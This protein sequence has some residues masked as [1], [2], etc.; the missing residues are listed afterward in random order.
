VYAVP[1]I[2]N[3]K[4]NTV[5][6][7]SSRAY[8]FVSKE[9][10][11]DTNDGLSRDAPVNTLARAIELAKTCRN[12]LIMDGTYNE[13]DLLV[14]YDLN[15]KG[16]GN[17]T[18]TGYSLDSI[19]EIRADYF[20][21]KNI[22]VEWVVANSFIKQDSGKS[23]EISK[24]IFK[25]NYVNT[26]FDVIS[27]LNVSSSIIINNS[28]I[29]SPN[30]EDADLDFNWWGNTK[31][32]YDV[33]PNPMVNNWLFLNI[34]ADDNN[35]QLNEK[36]IVNIEYNL[37]TKE[38]I[39]S[40]EAI[41]LPKIDMI[42][43]SLNG[44]V[45]K[46]IASP[47]DKIIYAL[48]STDDGVMSAT[49]NGIRSSIEFTFIRTNPIVSVNVGDVY[50]GSDVTVEVLLPGDATGSLTVTAGGIT[51]IQNISSDKVIFNLSD[52]PANNYTLKTTYSGDNHYNSI[53]VT[54]EF[55]VNKFKSTAKISLG[56]VVVGDDVV[57]N[58][59]VPYDA[60]G[61]VTVIVNG[62]PET[63]QV[64]NSLAQYIIFNIARGDYIIN[65]TYNGD[66]KYLKSSDS[67][68]FDVDKLNTTF[69]AEVRDIIYGE[70]TVIRVVLNDN[71]TGTITAKIG[72]K[73]NASEVVGGM[74]EII[75][76]KVDAGANKT[77]Y[78]YYGGD[79]EYFKQNYTLNYNVYKANLEFDLTV[80]DIM[81]GKDAVVVIN[82]PKNIGGTF[83]ITCIESQTVFASPFGETRYRISD[84]KIGEY[85]V[86]VEYNGNNYNTQIKSA[87]FN[88]N[89]YPYPIWQNDGFD[90]QNTGKSNY[91]SDVRQGVKLID[92]VSTAKNIVIDSEGNIYLIYNNSIY[93]YDVAGKIRWIYANN[94]FYGNFS[95]LSISRD[96][97]I[98]PKAGDTLYFINQTTGLQ[99]GHSNIYQGSSDFAPVVDENSNIYIMS[100]YQYDSDSYYL[101]IIPYDMWEYGG[102]P[103]W[104]SLGKNKPFSSPTVIDDE[105]IVVLSQSRLRIIDTT[106]SKTISSKSGNFYPVRPVVDSGKNIYAVLSQSIVAYD[107]NGVQLW[108]T[109]ITDG[110]GDKLYIDNNQGLV[111][112]VNSKGN[113]YKY[114]V[115]TGDEYLVSNLTVTSDILI[116]DDSSIYFGSENTLFAL[117]KNG[118]VLWKSDV[119]GTIVNSLVMDNRGVIYL[120]TSDKLY[121]VSQN[122]LMESNMTMK[123]NNISY[124]G[125]EIINVSLNA[126]A[127][128][129]ITF[130]I[131]GINYENT[132]IRTIEEGLV[133]LELEGLK[134]GG[135]TVD[136]Y[137]DGDNNFI[138]AGLTGS[139]DVLK[140]KSGI[141][142]EAID[143]LDII[144]YLKDENGSPIT[145][146]SVDCKVNDDAFS[147]LTDDNGRF[148]VAALS[149]CEAIFEFKN[150]NYESCDAGFVLKDVRPLRKA[151]A[152][153]VENQFTR[154]ANDFNAGE[155]GAM[156]YFVL[157]DGD[158]NILS[159]KSAKIGINGV[160]YS[161][162][163][164]NDGKAGL[165]INL[166]KSTAYTYAIAYLGDDEYNASFSVSKLNLIKKPL[167]ITPKKTSYTFKSGDK[168]KYVE[169]TLSTIKNEFDGKMYLSQGKKVTL[170]INGKTYTAAAAKNGAI[171]F[172]I[173]SL[174]KKGTYKV[175]IK[176]A[177]DATY[178]AGTSKTITI[179]IS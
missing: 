114:D 3:A 59:T 24:I 117:N 56:P 152:I 22:L 80:S 99:Y 113:L 87:S 167:T 139:F 35:L 128:G 170:T 39:I 20:T 18:I 124:G 50:V 110:A 6:L 108:K 95:G 172:N 130:K 57:L 178:E 177:G 109:P 149:N 29:V 158:G 30:L 1:S 148:K 164:D 98:A 33:K 97:I 115:F 46:N 105:R 82:T 154:Y 123:I 65:V 122:P 111:Y 163:T 137:Y 70:D 51:Q 157:K 69:A 48:N 52:L 168:N 160:I 7:I 61:N 94:G 75:L 121:A 162:V 58:I 146:V 41:V 23:V 28:G 118:D 15:I 31:E 116:G 92:N 141:V 86:S 16:E 8:I 14:D 88:V 144:G 126:D 96:V 120:T 147:V 78:L 106:T 19:F 10:G 133:G 127:T 67:V 85:D 2:G 72:D 119:G 17:A 32:N 76:G 138:P 66:G 173:G 100:E 107:Y 63:V 27:F 83:T 176:Y 136:V 150:N 45:S 12:I 112:C 165:Q 91:S 25:N 166:A 179:K 81:I 143:G 161:V 125:V 43:S 90:V 104:I 71:A 64:N 49:Y 11:N 9:R 77:I 38:G 131:T 171:K 102:T 155:R 84:L 44:N 151:T 129:N 79:N 93:S 53:T 42:I 62:N 73:T 159:N 54:N 4:T 37:I 156:F 140:I 13:F 47:P 132:F 55:K 89:E 36:A 74:A 60:T 153:D 174:T 101:V 135:Y 142:I 169:A 34:S 103:K 145:N 40:K 21:L 134:C 175:T 5:T 26:L 68:V